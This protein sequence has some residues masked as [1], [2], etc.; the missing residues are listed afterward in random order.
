MRKEKLAS[1][2]DNSQWGKARL[3]ACFTSETE[4]ISKMTSL[5]RARNSGKEWWYLPLHR[6]AAWGCAWSSRE[7]FPSQGCVKN[8]NLVAKFS[9]MSV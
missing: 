5:P 1:T 9:S 3:C 6:H 7:P 2:T 8:H 4:A